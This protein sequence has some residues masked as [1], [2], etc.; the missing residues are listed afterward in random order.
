[1][2]RASSLRLSRPK[3]MGRSVGVSRVATSH[4]LVRAV[5]VLVLGGPLDRGNDV[6]V[7]RATT[8]RAGDRGAD[9]LVGRMRV[10]V[11]QRARG[12]EHPRCAEA[13]VQGVHLVEALLERVQLTAGLE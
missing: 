11:Q 6:L 9:L 7:A 8:D 13:A 3:P 4:L 12:H 1:M 5:A 2:K 10:L